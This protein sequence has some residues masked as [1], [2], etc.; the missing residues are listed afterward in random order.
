MMLFFEDLR[1]LED[2]TIQLILR[3]LEQEDLRLALKG[4]DENLQEVIFKNMS[5]RAADS[6]KEDMELLVL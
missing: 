2:R 6:L 3:E 5:Q 4:A 1:K